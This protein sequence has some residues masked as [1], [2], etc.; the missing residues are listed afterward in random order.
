MNAPIAPLAQTMS[1]KVSAQIVAATLC[2]ARSDRQTP[3]GLEP[4]WAIIRPEHAD[5][6]R[7]G[8]R[9]NAARCL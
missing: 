8:A 2:I 7:N 1:C 3:G 4:G 9:R 5:A 6:I